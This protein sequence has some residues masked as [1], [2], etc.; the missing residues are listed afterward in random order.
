MEYVFARE[1]MIP[2]SE[3]LLRVVE[4]QGVDKAIERFHEMKDQYRTIYRYNYSE[5]E[6]NTLGYTLL[7]DNKIE[8]AIEIFKLNVSEHPKSWN[9][10]DS[11]GEAY[12]N[13]GE[14]ELA[15]KNYQKSLK[16][17][18]NNKNGKDMLEK[19]GIKR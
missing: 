15:I 12:M 7:R 5:Q 10:Y 18:P 14:K 17:N 1:R 4:H 16:L 3:V 8:A 11:L 19:L 13:Q 6:I 2:A 9:V